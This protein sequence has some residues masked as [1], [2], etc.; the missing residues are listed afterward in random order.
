[1][2]ELTL[3]FHIALMILV[4][5]FFAFISH[6]LKQPNLLGYILAGII[7]GP[8]G[9]NLIP[10]TNEILTLSELGIAFLLFGAGIEISFERLRGIGLVAFANGTLQIILTILISLVAIL[11]FHLD[12]YSSIYLAVA[13]SFSSTTIV[14]KVLSDNFELNTLH[15][16]LIIGILIVQD[17]AAIILLSLL[18]NLSIG[19]SAAHI[20]SLIAKAGLLF[21]IGYLLNKLVFPKLLKA[22][23]K[24]QELLFLTAIST[25]FFF[26]GLA[27][28]LGF[29]IAIGALIG[30]ISLS[31]LQ[32]ETEINGKIRTL[33]DF[34]AIIFFVSL[35]MQI[36]LNLSPQIMQLLAV[37]ILL[38]MIIKPIILTLIHLT[39]GYGGRTSLTTG[40]GLGQMSEFSFI[41]AVQGVSL[42]LLSQE[43]FTAVTIPI[44]LTIALT[45]Y[46]FK[47]DNDLYL[48]LVKTKKRFNIPNM[49]FIRRRVPKTKK[50]KQTELKN[51]VI[52]IGAHRMGQELIKELHKKHKLVIIDYDPEVIKKLVK[53]GYNCI[54]GD[55]YNDFILEK[56][57]AHK[58]K[59]A[60]LTIPD[61]KIILAVIA[62]LKK[63]NPKIKIFTRA[64]FT[65]DAIKFY[66][67]GANAVIM[68]EVIA[69]Q[70]MIKKID[71]LVKDDKKIQELSKEHLK[72]LKKITKK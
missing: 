69:G 2:L 25:L 52:L 42:G 47:Y 6:F 35:G 70:K 58:A 12:F 49:P 4:A 71:L 5:T 36:S 51:H 44:I 59:L 22:A 55:V 9:L 14:L 11:N 27:Y 17:I 29:S 13:V 32:F 38:T 72:Q 7:L 61:D 15:G 64:N 20:T 62:K 46:L 24:S 23:E 57:K 45:P 48:F 66:E 67:A 40:I 37:I 18:G 60:V 54:Y 34:F 53:K 43:L 63:M 3:I 30:G 31:L 50:I 16:R 33:R 21:L 68:P 26:M 41:I 56:A 1:M 65:E 39:M 8:V 10:N 19:L 28:D